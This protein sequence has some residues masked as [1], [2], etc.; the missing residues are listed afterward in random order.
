MKRVPGLLISSFLTLACFA[1]NNNE[2]ATDNDIREP[3]LGISFFLNDFV[4]PQRIRSQSLTGV[5]RD[6]KIASIREMAPGIGISYFKGL[7]RHIDFAAT[8]AGSF[9]A[10]PLSNESGIGAGDRFL[11]EGDASVNLK[12]MDE[13]YWF[14]PYLIAGV[15]ASRYGDLFGAFIPVGGGIKV[16]FF[17]EAALFIISQYRIPVINDRNNYHFM[18]SIGIAGIIGSKKES[19]LKSVDLPQ[20]P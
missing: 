5:L 17:N 20:T 3:A 10:I 6:K 2:S 1:Q 16:N 4:T 14:T 19:P 7:K 8:V 15:G 12:M 13:R 11:L 18:N 9:A